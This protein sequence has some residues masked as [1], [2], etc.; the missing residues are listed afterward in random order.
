MDTV[1]LNKTP[2]EK[3]LAIVAFPTSGL[4][5]VIAAKHLIESLELPL[6]GYLHSQKLQPTVM[7][8]GGEWEPPVALY[9][10]PMACGPGAKCKSLLLATSAVPIEGEAYWE[11]AAELAQLMRD[12]GVGFTAVLESLVVEEAEQQDEVY[13]VTT[14][15]AAEAF[16]DEIGLKPFEEG[17]LSG[18]SG[19]LLVEARP[20]EADIVVLIAE[21]HEGHP[22]HT[23]AAQLMKI[24]SEHFLRV[25]VDLEPLDQEAQRIEENIRRTQRKVR[26]SEQRSRESINTMYR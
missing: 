7:I 10:K 22:D 24:V 11:V 25:H 3:P 5:G 6:I 21:A 13:R 1:F 20:D 19:A 15:P 14:G 26:A 4:P 8:R 16:A 2:L 18:V 9:G 17:A 12:L 23:S